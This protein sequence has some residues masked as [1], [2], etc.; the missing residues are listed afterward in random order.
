MIENI[1]LL[2]GYCGFYDTQLNKIDQNIRRDCTSFENPCP[3]IF[4]SSDSYKCK[5]C[6]V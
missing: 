4:N 3:S 5:V 2:K 1:D 6:F